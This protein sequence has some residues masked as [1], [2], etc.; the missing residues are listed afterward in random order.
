M[1]ICV[2]IL[3]IFVYIYICFIKSFIV[4]SLYKGPPAG[5]INLII[6]NKMNT[7]NKKTQK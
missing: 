3:Y 6:N 5:K 1:F 2:Y 7:L 4:N